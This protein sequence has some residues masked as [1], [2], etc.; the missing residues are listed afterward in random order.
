MTLT[1][2]ATRWLTDR[3]LSE[4]TIQASGLFSDSRGRGEIIAVPYV[5]P[6]GK[7][8]GCKYRHLDAGEDG[9]AWTQDK[10]GVK[11][12]YRRDVISEPEFANEPL[13]I[14]E[15]EWDALAAIEA[16]FSRVVSVPNGAP[17]EPGKEKHDYFGEAWDDIRKCDTIIIATD[18]DKP[19]EALRQDIV[20]AFG[21]V[22]CKV[23]KYPKGCKD[24]GD[25]LRKFGPEAVRLSLTE[26][27]SDVPVN[28]VYTLD[29]IPD[30]PPLRPIKLR[31]LGHDFEKHIG[32]CKG[33]VSFW[34]GWAN[35]GKTAV[36]R[37]LMLALA[38]EHEWRIGCAMLEDK[39]KRTLVPAMRQSVLRMPAHEIT[40]TD[41]T[42]ADDFIRDQFRFIIPPDD[43]DVTV[44][45][46]LERAEACVRRHRCDMVVLDP[47][48]ELDLQTG[49][50]V[51]ENELIKNYLT[52]FTKFA[53]VLDVHVAI[54]AHPRKAPEIGGSKKMPSGYDISGSA[55]F[56]NKCHLGVSIQSDEEIDNLTDIWVWKTK[57]AEIMG[58]RGIFHLQF[59]PSTL[60]FSELDKA[61]VY[62]WRHPEADVVDINSRRGR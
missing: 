47:W 20:Y 53:R 8:A 30:E 57:Y 19:G 26:H 24:L 2:A 52:A 59:D 33:Q 55:H 29:E 4:D 37:H 61:T 40:E 11:F 28:G 5:D 23:A 44:A 35:R 54:I 36:M 32:V 22:R 12:L 50:P 34:T 56:M 43:S 15:G 49:G 16:G 46:F 27:A 62:E 7:P 13:I 41:R 48:T 9:N 18:N 10:G 6:E 14:T 31:T 51:S 39:V 38:H 25:A 58:P 42:R 1:P 3:G 21:R 17:A 60:R 45:W